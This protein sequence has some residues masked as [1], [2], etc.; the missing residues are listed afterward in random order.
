M[1]KDYKLAKVISLL[2]KPEVQIY[3]EERL[4]FGAWEDEGTNYSVV[5]RHIL[6][7]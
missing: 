1:L 2:T 6:E 5:G 7:H 4:I 3:K